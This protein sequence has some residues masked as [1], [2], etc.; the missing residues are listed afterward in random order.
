MAFVPGYIYD[1][2]RQLLPEML[3]FGLVGGVGSV[4]DLGGAALLHGSYGVNALAAKAISTS[5]AMVITYVFSRFWTFKDGD[6]LEVKRQAVYFIVLNL[7][8]LLIAEA[9]V[10]LFTDVAGLR[11]QLAFNLASFFGTGLGTIFRYITYRKWVF[12]AAPQTTAFAAAARPRPVPAAYTPWEYAPASPASTAYAEAA[13]WGPAPAAPWEPAG[14]PAAGRQL[15]PAMSG[16]SPVPQAAPWGPSTAAPHPVAHR[17][18]AH[19]RPAT[20]PARRSPGRHRK[21]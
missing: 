6:S 1:R 7:I 20:A 19:Q 16:V 11:G 10:G 5:V 12:I 15:T 2:F 9:V 21:H 17:P 4:F 14:T 8:G 13:P 3:R 18:A